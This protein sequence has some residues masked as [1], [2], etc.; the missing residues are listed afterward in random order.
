MN[1][2]RSNCIMQ[3]GVTYDGKK[4][5]KN[6]LPGDSPMLERPQLVQG[7]TEG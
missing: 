7:C 5:K 4:E 2:Y 6:L 1:E 3:Y